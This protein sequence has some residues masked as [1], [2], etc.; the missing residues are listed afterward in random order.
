MKLT[1]RVDL[2]NENIE[3]RL[4]FLDIYRRDILKKRSATRTTT[5]IKENARTLARTHDADAFLNAQIFLND[6]HSKI[7]C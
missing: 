3:I 7:L 4:R 6:S 1:E 2:A 5:I